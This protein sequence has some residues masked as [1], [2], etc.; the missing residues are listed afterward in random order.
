MILQNMI[1]KKSIKKDI[2]IHKK[3]ISNNFISDRYYNSK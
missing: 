3:N 2:E 1:F